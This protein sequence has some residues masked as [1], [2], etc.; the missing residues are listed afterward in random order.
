MRTKSRHQEVSHAAHKLFPLA[1]TDLA[2][3]LLEKKISLVV[4]FPVDLRATARKSIGA[5]S[6]EDIC[7]CALWKSAKNMNKEMEVGEEADALV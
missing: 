4:M 5:G 6:G 7:V 2:S 1:A 3:F